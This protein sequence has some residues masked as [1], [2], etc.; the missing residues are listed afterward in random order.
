MQFNDVRPESFI[1][2]LRCDR[3]DLEAALDDSEF[4]EFV[5]VDHVAGYA[6]VFGGGDAVQL[7]LC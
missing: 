4:H 6:P 3:C 1:K 2:A 7:D 5:S